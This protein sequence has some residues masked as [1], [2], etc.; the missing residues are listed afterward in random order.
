MCDNICLQFLHDSLKPLKPLET[1]LNKG[2]VKMEKIWRTFILSTSKKITVDILLFHSKAVS[3]GSN[4]LVVCPGC[5][6]HTTV[7]R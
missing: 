6:G 7:T 1:N 2:F 5:N 4:D 3:W